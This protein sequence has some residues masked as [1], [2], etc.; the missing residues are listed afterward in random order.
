MGTLYWQI[1]DIYPVASWSSI[2]YYG[3]YKA[4]HYVAKR[5]YSPILL[6][7]E[8]TGETAT[9][10][11]VNLERGY[12]DYETKAALCLTNDTREK[13]SGIIRWA[14]RKSDSSIIKSG[15]F[16]AEVEAFSVNRLDELD[17]EKT[18]VYNNYMSFEYEV[19]GKIISEG[20]VLFT[21]PKHYNFK[22]PDLRYEING[23]LLQFRKRVSYLLNFDIY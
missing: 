9:R 11:F 19:N 15:E 4:L 13:V 18:D 5:F 17:F 14:L 12:F 2:D 20:T 10:P 21:A 3:R 16:E 1:N 8:E 23:S 7:C 6:S 22:N